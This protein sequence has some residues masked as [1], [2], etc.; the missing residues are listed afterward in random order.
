MTSNKTKKTEREDRKK[1]SKLELNT[2]R[3]KIEMKRKD[4][5]EEVQSIRIETRRN[6]FEE[7]IC[8]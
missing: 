5:Q 4:L 2:V 1:S 8:S 6:A 7:Y 3:A